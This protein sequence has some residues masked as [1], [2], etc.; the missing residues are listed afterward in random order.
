MHAL[1]DTLGDREV[2]VARRKDRP[3]GGVIQGKAGL[4]PLRPALLTGGMHQ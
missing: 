3:A 1:N 4:N 2:G